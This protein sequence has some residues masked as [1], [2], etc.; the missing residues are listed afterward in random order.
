MD[1]GH[2]DTDHDLDLEEAR[3]KR[4]DAD[5]K[6]PEHPS[7]R[8]EEY[9][10]S[11]RIRELPRLSREEQRKLLEME[12]AD[13]VEKNKDD[14]DREFG[15]TFHHNKNGG[16]KFDKKGAAQTFK[17]M[18]RRN[19]E[20]DQAW[21][22]SHPYQGK[23]LGDRINYALGLMPPGEAIDYWRYWNRYQGNPFDKNN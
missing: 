4:K 17:E 13:L 2:D 14:P 20:F 15:N 18:D 16:M 3:K 6:A 19:K 12:L 10:I 11:R 21:K 1:Y 8:A 5:G 7:R 22:R 23:N 9:R